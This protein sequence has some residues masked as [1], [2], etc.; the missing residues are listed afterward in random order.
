MIKKKK[1][2]LIVDVP[3]WAWD[4]KANVLMRY[5]PQYDFT[6]RYNGGPGKLG[7]GNIVNISKGKEYDKIFFF[8]WNDCP[9]RIVSTSYTSISSHNFYLL[10]PHKAESTLKMFKGIITVSPE[11]DKLVK[12]Y[13]PKTV[14]APNGV[15]HHLFKP[16]QEEIDTKKQGEFVVGIVGQK[17]TGGFP[18]QRPIDMKG[19]D[20]ILTPLMKQ[21]K[22]YTSIRFS[23]WSKNHR[24]GIN[25][26]EMPKFYNRIDCFI[27][28]SY[29]EGT[30][31]PVF[32]AAACGVPIIAPM[33]GCIPELINDGMNGFK[34]PAYD[35]KFEAKET[36]N[37]IQEKILFLYNNKKKCK[38]M[39][40]NVRDTIEKIWTWEKCVGP[41]IKIFDE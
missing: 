25:I 14:C 34:V 9:S 24:N 7:T 29:R 32:E 10:H 30:P 35:N 6:K 4:Y 28:T 5:L 16:N 27:N 38:E 22:K 31:N 37:Q 8:G 18:P 15:N 1:I 13:N 3:N 19:F 12:K 36:I 17:T 33:V 20:I 2:L 41:Y 26:S 21:M 39:G 23:I 40:K 11:L